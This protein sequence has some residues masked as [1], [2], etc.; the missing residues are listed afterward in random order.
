MRRGRGFTLLEMLVVVVLIALTTAVVLPAVIR[1]TA[2]SAERGWREDFVVL[3]GAMPLT[4]FKGGRSMRLDADDLRRLVPSLPMDVEIR[5]DRP[6]EYAANGAAFGGRIE[7]R[8][9]TGKG[10]LLASWTVEP[11][12]GRLQP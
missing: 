10:D 9:G 5:L 7:L 6:L 12:S 1:W 3:V 8:R 11:I 2:A 4:A